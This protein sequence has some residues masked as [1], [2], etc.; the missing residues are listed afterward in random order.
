MKIRGITFDVD[1]HKTLH[2]EAFNEMVLSYGEKMDPAFFVYKNDFGPTRESKVV[3]REKHK[4][5]MPICQKG[6]ID[7]DFN[8]LPFGFD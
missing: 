6:I 5:Y 7:E 2:Y 1:N 8:V 3:M 4:M